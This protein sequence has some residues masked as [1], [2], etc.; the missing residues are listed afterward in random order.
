MNTVPTVYG[1]LA[2]T[3]IRGRLCSLLAEICPGD[4]NGFIINAGGAD[5]NEAAI[6]MAR[7]YTKK[8]KIISLHRSYHGTSPSAL[9]LTGD[10]RKWLIGVETPGILKA[11]STHT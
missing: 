6:R 3:E 11:S 8:S 9:S 1:G 10:P 4:I 2:S 7:R 5:A